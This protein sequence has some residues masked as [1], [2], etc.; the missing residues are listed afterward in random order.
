MATI[1]RRAEWWVVYQMAGKGSTSGGTAVCTQ[2]E[3]DAMEIARP[4][5][6]TLVRE[7]IANEAEAER[8]ARGTSGDPVRKGTPVP[9][10][11]PVVT[12]TS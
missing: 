5:H 9:A 3:W 8:L 10:P 1:S 6:H 4:G 12:A 2:D 11:A 7:R